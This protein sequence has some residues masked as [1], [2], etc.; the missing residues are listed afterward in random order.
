VEYNR[1]N[2]KTPE[3]F[4]RP[5]IRGRKLDTKKGSS[6][7]KI[8][9]AMP[10]YNEGKYVGS[11]VLQ[12]RQ[13]ADEVIVV[14]D[15]S[16]D[17]TASVAG[18]AG[19]SVVRH[20]ENRG[21]GSAIQSIMTE[22]KKQDADILVILDADSQH[23]PEEIPSLVKAVSEGSDVVIGSRAMQRSEI[24]LYRRLGQRVLS[25]LTRVASRKT[26]SDTESGFR[27]YSRKA[28]DTLELKETG[29]AVSSEIIS[30][31]TAKGLKIT[32]VPVSVIYTEDGSTLNPIRHGIGVMNR[33][34]VMISERRPIFFFGLFGGILLVIGLVIGVI[35]IWN[36]YFS[37]NILATGAALVS[38]LLVTS[39]LLSIFTGIIL[40]V[41]VKRI[42]NQL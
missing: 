5:V 6:R 39:G 7:P 12:A 31:A 28:I 42:G 13:Y 15:G 9:A 23:N 18:L 36:Y 33:I 38:I 26:L 24:A 17:H 20:T 29:M 22:A 35:V 21:Y 1:E 25:R 34:L 11:L 41:L 2:Q 10:A 4:S 19:A 27:A 37:T 14:D 3:L 16:T 32:E 8:I 40:N 30:E